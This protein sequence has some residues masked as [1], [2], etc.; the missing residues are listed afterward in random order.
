MLLLL[1][2]CEANKPY[3]QYLSNLSLIFYIDQQK[4]VNKKY[5]RKLVLKI[6]YY[7]THNKIKIHSKTFDLC[8]INVQNVKLMTKGTSTAEESWN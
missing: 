8:S 5:F 7:S 1:S 6:L 4:S 2:A 3:F